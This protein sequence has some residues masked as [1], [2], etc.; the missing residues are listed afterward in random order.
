MA[1][2]RTKAQSCP[3]KSFSK[4]KGYCEFNQQAH[5]IWL[6]KEQESEA[7][8]GKRR[9]SGTA[10]HLV[11]WRRRVWDGD[12]QCSLQW[13]HV[14]DAESLI[15]EKSKTQ[16]DVE[17]DDEQ[18]LQDKASF[19]FGYTEPWAERPAEGSS[20]EWHWKTDDL[21]ETKPTIIRLQT[22]GFV[23]KSI[24]TTQTSW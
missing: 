15:L 13:R 21:P 11:L 2:E 24:K 8:K 22:D 23:P 12:V 14:C 1:L 10:D 7:L 5:W 4:A 19:E 6:V 17:R 20:E 3:L 16:G 18:T 9:R